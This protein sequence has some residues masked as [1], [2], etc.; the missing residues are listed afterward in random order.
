MKKVNQYSD[1]FKMHVVYEYLNG[2][3]SKEALRREYGIR[4]GS[5]ILNWIRKFEGVKSTKLLMGKNSKKTKE[6]LLKEIELLKKQLEYE[7]LRSVAFDTMIDVAEE[8]LNISI[9][10]KFGA[11]QSKK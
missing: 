8:E 1:E 9:R 7:K 3:K 11:K 10:K 5:A 4:G 2:D 6:D